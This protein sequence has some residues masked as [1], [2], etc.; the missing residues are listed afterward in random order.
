MGFR[1]QTIFDAWIWRPL[2]GPLNGLLYVL[3]SPFRCGGRHQQKLEMALRF[4]VALSDAYTLPKKQRHLAQCAAIAFVYRRIVELDGALVALHA[5]SILDGSPILVEGSDLRSRF[6]VA[7]IGSFLEPLKCALFGLAARP[8]PLEEKD[9]LCGVWR[10]ACVVLC[11]V[12]RVSCVVCRV[13]C[14]VSWAMSRMRR[15]CRVSLAACRVSCNGVKCAACRV[16][17]AACL[18]PRVSRRVYSSILP[19]YIGS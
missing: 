10:V 17:N 18:A 12:C 11:V 19:D 4:A 16:S 13:S 1:C 7:L 3:F 14:S 2:N 9:A 5:L 15:V 6:G 8:F